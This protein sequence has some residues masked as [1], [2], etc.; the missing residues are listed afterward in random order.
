MYILLADDTEDGFHTD[1]DWE[2]LLHEYQQVVA[3]DMFKIIMIIINM[4]E[5]LYEVLFWGRRPE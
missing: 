1:S 2:P 3:F 5:F 4:S